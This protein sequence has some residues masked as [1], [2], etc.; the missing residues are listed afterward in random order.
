MVLTKQPRA[1]QDGCPPPPCRELQIHHE[2]KYRLIVADSASAKF[3]NMPSV[4]KNQKFNQVRAWS[5]HPPPSLFFSH[6][7]PQ[8]QKK[9]K[10]LDLINFIRITT[11]IKITTLWFFVLK[12]IC[13]VYGVAN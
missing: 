12:R 8:K 9:K 3:S 1:V 7:S 6:Y 5:C 13:H 2:G 11:I 10:N 4:G